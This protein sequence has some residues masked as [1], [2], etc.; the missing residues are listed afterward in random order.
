MAESGATGQAFEPPGPGSWNRDPVHFPRPVTRYFAETHPEPFLRGTSEFMAFYGAPLGGMETQYVNGYAYNTMRPAPDEEIPQ[1]FARA[2]EVWERKVWREQLEEWD[3]QAKPASIARHRELQAVDP[4]ALSDEDLA[5]YL[6]QCRDHHRQMMY[7]HMRFTASAMLPVG[8]LLAHVGAW[9]T[10]TP[11]DALAMMRGSAPVSAGA[12]DELARLIAA[13][14]GDA[15]A[16]SLLESDGDPEKILTELRGA[17]GEVGAAVSGY[18]DLVGYR[19]LDGFD[20]SGRY[21]LELPD[22]L[23]RAIRSFVAGTADDSAEVDAR[24]ARIR[25]A[26]SRRAPRRVRRA[27]R[28]G[29]PHVPAARR[30]R[31]VQRH[32]GR[33]ASCAERRSAPVVAS[34]IGAACTTPST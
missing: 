32:L 20:I 12:S 11:A 29:T 34:P 26:G 2:E 21:A 30:A 10:V 19:L 28:R 15:A 25:D 9:T 22:A 5:A 3:E 18:L 8:D 16:R 6:E 23:V 24:T 7:Q 13:L 14:D 33:R 4:D 31:R 1:R 27:A 17:G